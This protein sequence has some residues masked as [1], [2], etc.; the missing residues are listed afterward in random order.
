MSKYK[1]VRWQNLRER[2]LKLDGYMCK[3]CR[4][5]GR[6]NTGDTVH[7]IYQAKDYPDLFWNIKNL[8]T[9]CRECHNEMHDRK[10]GELTKLGIELMERNKFKISPTQVGAKLSQ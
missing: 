5:Y 6:T 7:H 10:T 2:R 4:R 1:T 9:L 8:I 3:E